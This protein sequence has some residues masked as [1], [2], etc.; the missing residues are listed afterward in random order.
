M[1]NESKNEKNQR[2]LKRKKKIN[3]RAK[4]K[5]V[6]KTRQAPKVYRRDLTLQP[7]RSISQQ[8]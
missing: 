6:L 1:A 4:I 5:R 2:S 3:V 8:Y 7:T